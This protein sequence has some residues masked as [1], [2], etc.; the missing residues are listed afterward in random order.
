[1]TE[2]EW[3]RVKKFKDKTEDNEGEGGQRRRREHTRGTEQRSTTKECDRG[4][5]RG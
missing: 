3:E 1:V 2:E 4:D 5:G